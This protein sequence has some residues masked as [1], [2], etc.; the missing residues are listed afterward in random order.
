MP[1]FV[2][3]CIRNGLFSNTLQIQKQLIADYEEDI[4]KYA[5]GMGQSRILNVF[6]HIPVQLAKENKKF[7]ISK[8]AW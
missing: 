7:Q 3:E 6:R 5:D 4:T 8:V 1:A 2:S